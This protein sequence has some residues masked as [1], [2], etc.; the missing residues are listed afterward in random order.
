M[1]ITVVGCGKVGAT[2]IEH[3]TKEGHDVTVIDVDVNAVNAMS[4]TFDVLGVVG[5][6]ATFEV[7]AEAGVKNSDIL[8]A[9]TSSDEQNLLCCLIAKKAGVRYTIGRVRDPIYNSEVKYLQKE[10]GLA[11][12]INPELA[13][14]KEISRLLKYPSAITVDTFAG[15]NV[16]LLTVKVEKDSVLDGIKI[17]EIGSKIK[18]DVLICSIERK[19]E[20]FIPDGGSEILAG[21]R[22]SFVASPKNV[23]AFLRKIGQTVGN[24]KNAILVGG[25]DISRYLADILTGSG[26]DVKIIEKKKEKCVALANE[27]SDVTIINGDGMEQN[28]LL[29]EGLDGRGGFVALTNSDE[30]NIIMSLYAKSLGR[31][32]IVTKLSKLKIDGVVKNL[33]L[34]CFISPKSITA[35]IILRYVRAMKN[36]AGSNVEALYRISDERVEALE[37]SVKEGSPVIGKPLSQLKIKKGI[38]VA[39]ITRGSDIIIPKGNDMVLAGDSVIVVTKEESL[40]DVADILN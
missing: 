38:L 26:I 7:Q 14:A 30:E 21:D 12:I 16:E 5:N 25:G 13:T 2:L 36:S 31:T 27:F 18:C 10:L 22:I 34:D 37:F 11:L 9:V 4:E 32:K 1:K 20:V 6:G 15:G 24:V 40:L 35:N 8:I 28:L 17:S 3:L 23:A 39:C 33:G 29:E 19:D